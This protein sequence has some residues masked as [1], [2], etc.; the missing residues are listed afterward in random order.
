MRPRPRA[1]GGDATLVHAR[2][3]PYRT[4]PGRAV[5]RGKAQPP[6]PGSD[7][8]A[9]ERLV[10]SAF[11]S[12]RWR[13]RIRSRRLR[14][15]APTLADRKSSRASG[16]PEVLLLAELERT[17]SSAT[18][19]LGRACCCPRSAWSSC[20]A[21]PRFSI[22]CSNGMCARLRRVRSRILPLIEAI[23]RGRPLL[24]IPATRLLPGFA[25]SDAQTRER[26]T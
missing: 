11:A 2:G 26:E 16:A 9:D 12:A 6:D 4:R 5:P 3:H 17:R 19:V 18:S 13:A 10:A 24:Q 23:A 8:G 14:S 15:S 22:V 7:A 21:P 25:A 1:G 20:R